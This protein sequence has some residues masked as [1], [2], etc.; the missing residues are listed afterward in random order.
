MLEEITIGGSGTAIYIMGGAVSF[1]SDQMDALG[2]L[3]RNAAFAKI[4]LAPSVGDPGNAEL[5]TKYYKLFFRDVG[6]DNNFPGIFCHNHAQYEAIGPLKTDWT[7]ACPSLAEASQVEREEMCVSQAESFWGTTNVA[8]L[9]RIKRD[10]DP[11]NLFICTA[12]I[13]SSTSFKMGKQPKAPKAP[14]APKGPKGPKAPNAS[15]GYKSPKQLKKRK[16]P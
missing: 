16:Q 3:R 12:G 4:S 6:M 9:E 14:K 8:H 11:N 13:G 2:P 1:S 15:K 5:F 10:I 7:Q